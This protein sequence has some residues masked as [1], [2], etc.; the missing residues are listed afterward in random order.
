ME[1][2]AMKSKC[3]IFNYRGAP[4][5]LLKGMEVV[6]QLRYQGVTVVNKQNC[7]L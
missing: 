3:I 2:N 5:E 7:F 1:M 6:E 4:V